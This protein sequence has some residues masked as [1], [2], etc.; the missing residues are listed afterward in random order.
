M[1]VIPAPRLMHRRGKGHKGVCGVYPD[2]VVLIINWVKE[3]QDEGYSLPE[4]GHIYRE[5]SKREQGEMVTHRRS[6]WAASMFKELEERLERNG[7]KSI[8]SEVE[9]I[10]ERADGTIVGKFEATTIPR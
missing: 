1:G 6:S 3:K 9:I 4:V 8:L 7:R 10:E 2:D 5:Q